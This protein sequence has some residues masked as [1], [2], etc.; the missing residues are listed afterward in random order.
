V[1][2]VLT[3]RK[4]P[5]VGRGAALVLLAAFV[6]STTP[7]AQSRVT[8]LNESGWKAL[9]DRQP[10]LAAR[11]FAEALALRPNDPALMFGAGA[12][13]Y[14]QGRLPDA[15]WRLRRALDLDP[16]MT[17]ASRLLGE[18]TYGGGD[19]D[20]AIAIYEKALKYAPKDA[21]LAAKLA[22]WR[23][24]ADRHGTFTE[25]RDQMFTVLY[26]GRQEEA[27]AVKA[28]DIL[29]TAFRKITAR[30]GAQP[31]SSIYVVLYTER[32]FRDFTGSPDWAAGV[33]DGRIRVQTAGALKDAVSFERVLTH[34]LAHAIIWGLAPRGVPAWLH[35]GV[36]QY[37]AGGDIQGA[38]RR[39]RAQGSPVVLEDLERSFSTK[40]A[41]EA[42]LA[43]D[44]SLA[45]ASLVVERA[46][47]GWGTF[48]SDLA[49]GEPCE[50]ALIRRFGL[51]YAD[52]EAALAR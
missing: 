38:R 37:F 16:A 3:G 25:R 40:T 30:F 5:D 52:L 36:A 41:D 23:T 14:M 27:T 42:R 4:L 51:S 19:I 46:G 15:T 50:R 34:E 10:D 22:R 11:L 12:A 32:Q 18:V 20:G 8:Q 9:Q 2:R 35:E 33:Y 7:A 17:E 44:A 29:R 47:F 45:A 31:A 13:A 26:E 6:F 1:L 48:F 28:T 21:D 24:D 49:E 39:V 43:Y